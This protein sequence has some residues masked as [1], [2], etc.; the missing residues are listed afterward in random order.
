VH[1]D[2]YGYGGDPVVL[3][4][5]FGTSAFLW[6]D[7]APML[8]ERGIVAYAI[9][10][11]GYGESDRPFDADYGVAAQTDYMAR[12]MTAL[13]LGPATV[14]GVDVGGGV[15][16]RLAVEHP[17]RV[18]RLALVNSVGFDDWPGDDIRTLQRGTARLALRVARGMLG[19]APLLSPLL[20]G[21][22]A[23]P[24]NM[25]TPLI[26]RYLA[27]YVGEEGVTHLLT[28]ARSLEP[29]DLAEL[30]LAAIVA[31]TLVVWGE[32]D[33]WLDRRLSR[34]L[35]DAIPGSGFVALPGVAR[36]VPEE[37]PDRLAEL[38]IGLVREGVVGER[39]T[40]DAV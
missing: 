13:R 2:R 21:S 16:Q 1:V 17:E 26:A 24:A 7:V 15:A 14:V 8:V 3:L 22:V 25:P 34:R 5:G 30:D 29:D 20:E 27:P 10:L 36:L 32:E 4:H 23:D 18:A 39:S 38:I 35:H 40:E 19:V 12:A 33:Q 6:R 28:L 11:L 37:A 9:D 31:P